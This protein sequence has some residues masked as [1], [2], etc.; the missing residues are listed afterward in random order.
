V[1]NLDSFAHFTHTHAETQSQMPTMPCFAAPVICQLDCLDVR[2]AFTGAL[3]PDAVDLRP[4]GAPAGMRASFAS[5]R[6]APSP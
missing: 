2:R 3:E 5:P 4:H 6:I 1:A